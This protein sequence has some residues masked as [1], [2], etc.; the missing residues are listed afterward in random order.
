MAGKPGKT[1]GAWTAV[2]ALVL[3]PLLLAGCSSGPGGGVRFTLFPPNNT[4]M[5]STY[6]VRQPAQPPLPVPRE[7]DQRVLPAYTVEP[8]DSVIVQ[9]AD[10]DAP[11]QLPGD[12]VVMPD[13][14]ISLGQYGQVI[15]AGKTVRDIENLVRA[16]IQGSPGSKDPGPIVARVV[17][18]VSKIYYVLGE[19]N[20]PGAFPLQGRETVLDGIVAA[21]G[22]TDRASRVNSILSRPTPPDS[23]RIVLPVCYRQIVQLGDT[24]TNYQL[25]PGDRIYV[26]GRNGHESFFG[27]DHQKARAPCCE[28]PQS[29]CP[30]GQDDHEPRPAPAAILPPVA[31]AVP[32]LD[33]AILPSATRD[34]IGQPLGP[35]VGEPK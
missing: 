29:P 1:C 7:L 17:S 27:P 32:P 18:R 24:T 14:T 31:E 4:L 30:M 20:S 19:V 26:P 28:G 15:V 22:L 25:A 34:A 2:A 16:V 3:T 5:D 21:G 13:G 33:G 23:C 12:Q 6:A 35:A 9:P 11:V 8:G 10:L